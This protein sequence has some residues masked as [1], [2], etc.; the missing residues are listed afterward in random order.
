MVSTFG[1]L[2]AF[3]NVVLYGDEMGGRTVL[4]K[5]RR[6]DF[7][8]HVGPARLVSIDDLPLP[9]V[10]IHDRLPHGCEEFPV[11]PAGTEK[12]WGLAH[13]LV[14]RITAQAGEC[15]IDPQNDAIDISDEN[16]AGHRC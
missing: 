13:C 4:V 3:G 1:L 2:L 6:D 10:S 12:R 7:V 9:D 8:H 11:V 5:Q 14:C 15:L 16:C